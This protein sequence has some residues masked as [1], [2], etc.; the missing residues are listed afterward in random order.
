MSSILTEEQS[1]EAATDRLIERAR[2]L[3]P[4]IRARSAEAESLR[5]LPDE[6]MKDVEVFLDA[7]VPK[8][9]GGQG[10]GLRALCEVARELAHGDA[11]TAWT[12]SFLMEHSWMACHLPMATQEE[13]FKD[14]PYI[15]TAA[16]L[17]PAG[18]AERVDG[19]FRVHGTFRYAS[20]L[21]NADWIFVG[22]PVA[23]DSEDGATLYTFLLPLT[24]VTDNDDWFMS[25]MAAT[26]SGSVTIDG[27]FVPEG[28]AV[29]TVEFHSSD[30][31]AGAAHEEPIFKYP[32]PVSIGS[33]MAGISLG[34]AEACVEIAR[35]RLPKSKVF[36]TTPRLDLALS[37][38]RWGEALQKV[39][40]ARLLWRDTVERTI[41]KCDAVE[42]WT[43]AELGL[44]QLDQ[45]TV[46]HLS[47]QAV[48]LICD[49]MGSSIYQLS[50]PLQR[51]RRDVSLMANHAFQ[52]HDLVAERGTRFYLGLGRND[53]DP[54]MTKPPTVSS[55]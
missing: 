48:G 30:Q 6:T 27:A 54:D 1:F 21:A 44:F 43:E 19:G 16:P 55:R 35:E 20:C 51:Y 26:S 17:N 5:R 18:R 22:A 45:M 3:A 33:M 47:H 25:G 29:T 41:V 23:D 37:R 15:L 9:W 40:C 46:V 39:R 34:C 11:A 10:L 12:A 4:A 52:D 49:G 38:V 2:E 32:I 8:V 50:D 14:R 36:G 31:H 7:I 24:D 28:M 53:T 42:P 13:L